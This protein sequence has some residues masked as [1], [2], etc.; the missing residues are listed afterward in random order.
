[1][2]IVIV[3]NSLNTDLVTYFK[4]EYSALIKVYDVLVCK[5][6]NIEH[7]I[8]KN[9]FNS[10]FSKKAFLDKLSLIDFIISIRLLFKILISKSEIIHFTTAHGSN[11]FLSIILKPFHVK[12]VFTIHDLEPHPGFKSKFITFYNNLVINFLADKIL[13]FSKGSLSNQKRSNKFYSFPLSGFDQVIKTKKTGQNILFFGRI[14]QYKGLENLYI[15]A[16]ECYRRKLPWNFIV[17][18]KGDHPSLK[19]IS[20]LPNSTSINRFIEN[21]EIFELFNDS[22]FTIL[23]YSSATQSGVSILSFAYATPVLANNVGFLSEYIEDNKNGKLFN[24]DSPLDIV[25]YLS[26][27]TKEEILAQ[28]QYCIDIFNNKYSVES[29]KKYILEFFNNIQYE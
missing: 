11:L 9:Y 18:G 4:N 22:A 26:N 13:T 12:Q 8:F 21:K 1:M 27:V 16:K 24:P 10:S 15:I 25:N 19:K 29:Y 7:N 2:K 3:C 14:D 5:N 6:K 17:A 23:P 28:S 20:S